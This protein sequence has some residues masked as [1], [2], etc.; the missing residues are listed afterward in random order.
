MNT[1][2]ITFTEQQLKSMIFID[3]SGNV[4][5]PVN[6]PKGIR[7]MFEDCGFYYCVILVKEDDEIHESYVLYSSRF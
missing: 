6:P 1:K 5:L 3:E 7:Y 2:Y 4:E